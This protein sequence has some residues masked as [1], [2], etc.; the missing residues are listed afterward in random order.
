MFQNNYHYVLL[1]YTISMY[2]ALSIWILFISLMELLNGSQF[3]IIMI[4][5][6]FAAAAAATAAVFGTVIVALRCIYVHHYNHIDLTLTLK[7]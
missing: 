4:F 1:N 5:L 6:S 3:L 7:F 2:L